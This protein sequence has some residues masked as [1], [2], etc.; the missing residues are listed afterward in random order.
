MM[1]PSGIDRLAKSERFRRGKLL[2]LNDLTQLT[3]N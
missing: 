1:S 2:L 3:A